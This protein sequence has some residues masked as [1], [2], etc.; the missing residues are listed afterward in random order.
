MF[1]DRE[2]EGVGSAFRTELR[3]CLGA[4][5]ARDARC[6]LACVAHL[7]LARASNSGTTRFAL[8]LWLSAFMSDFRTSS[9][10]RTTQ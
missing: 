6:S 3:C 8:E 7:Q 5:A 9:S 10:T 2:D 1:K 4:A